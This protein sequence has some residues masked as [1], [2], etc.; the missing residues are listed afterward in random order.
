MSKPIWKSCLFILTAFGVPVL[1][2]SLVNADEIPVAKKTTSLSQDRFVPYSNED[3]KTLLAQVTSISQ[4]RDVSPN[5]W[6][7]EALRNLVEEYGCLVGYPDGNYRGDRALTRYEFA[8]GMNACLQAVERRLLESQATTEPETPVTATSTESL[9][10]TFNRAF[11]HNSGDYFEGTDQVGQLNTIFGFL[12]FQFPASFP[13]NQITRDGELIEV[14][15]KDAMAQQSSLPDVKTRDLANPF[16]TSLRENP[17]YLRPA[18][19]DGGREII[20]E[21]NP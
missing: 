18:A 3:G 12:P 21:R 20:I 7:F 11:S 15:Y 17:N 14:I 5:T 1:L 10:E 16:N 19:A 8:A 2:P 13:E 4:F 9:S 6:A